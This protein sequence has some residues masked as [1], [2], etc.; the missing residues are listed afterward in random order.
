MA[1]PLS[2][3]EATP[4]RPLL[5]G[6]GD[7]L[8]HTDLVATKLIPPRLRLGAIA[9]PR[10]I[11]RLDEIHNC[12]LTLLSAPAGSGK[13]T[14]I[15]E[16]LAHQ[17]SPIA[18]VSLDEGDDDPFYFWLYVA[19]ALEGACPG[20]TGPT[21][22]LLRAPQTPLL[23][24]VVTTLL[25][26]L[27]AVECPI[28][29]VLDDYHAITNQETH[30]LLAYMLDRLPE[31]VHVVLTSR[32]DPPLPLARLRARGEL[33][34]L[35]APEL[36]F[37]DEEAADFLAQTMGLRLTPEQIATLEARTEGWIAG[38]QLAALS[39][40]GQTDTAAFLASFS[41]S[42]RYIVDYLT[43][44]VLGQQPTHI[45]SFLLRTS[46]LDQ[47]GGPL[48]DAVTGRSDSSE[49]LTYLEQSNLFLI[50]LDDERRWL[51]YHA[52]FSEALRQRFREMFPGEVAGL[53]ERASAWFEREGM[54][55]QAM[56]HALAAGALDSAAA[57]AERLVERYWKQGAIGAACALLDSIPNEIMPLRPRLYLLRAWIYLVSGR[58]VAGYHWLGEAERLLGGI[59][60]Y[61]DAKERD[62]LLGALLA[63]K[64]TVARASGEFEEA[65]ALSYQ[66]L[67]LEPEDETMWRMIV[68]VNLGQIAGIRGEVDAAR[69]AFAQVARLSE[70][71]GDDFGMHTAII[72]M[73]GIEEDAGHLR[74]AADICRRGLLRY[75]QQG[76]ASS[77]SSGYLI[78]VLGT[79]AY[80]W[81]Q[82]DE[83][84]RLAYESIEIGRVGEV[85]DV[86]YNGFVILARVQQA[87]SQHREALNA[88]LEA[89]RLAQE[90]RMVGLSIHANT[91]TLQLQLAQGDLGDLAH[92]TRAELASHEEGKTFELPIWGPLTLL[93]HALLALG[94]AT[95][96][97]AV[98]DDYIATVEE[99]GQI[100]VLIR[101][102][103]LQALALE[104]DGKPDLGL[105]ALERAL[106]LA[107]PE[108]YVRSFLDFGQPMTTLLQRLAASGRDLPISQDYLARLL[109]ASDAAPDTTANT[110]TL[111]EDLSERER[112]VLILMAAGAANQEIAETL[113]VSIHTVKTHVAHILAKLHAANRTQAVARARELG[114]I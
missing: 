27:S 109:N 106:H 65:K 94:R 46:L 53:H 85:F 22:A 24:S 31:Q 87:R 15:G 1:T 60:E 7:F 86:I 48:C 49:I 72:G 33:L 18:W 35:R 71:G 9:R 23:R 42:H 12:R 73:S 28:V 50:P 36:R 70:Q 99:R 32:T 66:A 55:Q 89:E 76:R 43:D 51:R 81:N 78:M 104:A 58:F 34:E 75:Q 44:E 64:A 62:T 113:V 30:D 102:L 4:L 2:N 105:S 83:A 100:T 67:A 91:W 54:L 98:L 63:I 13:T 80:E 8:M 17:Q 112:E 97:L 37:T 101:M 92:W 61:S 25:N 82:L 10:L 77:P 11:S 38:L 88:A 20:A 103:A 57:L 93:P 14:V 40:R 68:A 41:G 69:E 3:A 47:L 108:G 114:L 29:L 107:E 16:W 19:T 5:S 39:L 59:E 110:Q 45:R 95:E 111:E 90:G 79:L 52:L 96:A 6:G 56:T 26:A 21:L 84:E 74:L